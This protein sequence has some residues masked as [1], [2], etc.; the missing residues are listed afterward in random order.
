[1]PGGGP[2]TT[3]ITLGYDPAKGRFVGSF[4]ASMMDQFWI[5][6]GSLEGDVLSLDTEGPAFSGEGRSPYRDQVELIGDD[7]RILRSLA[8][9]GNGGW[10][11]FM[12][13]RYRRKT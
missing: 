1:M 10:T 3:V 8:P 6:E 9:D 12:T 11:E 7:E 2:A 4:I 13:A 5:Y